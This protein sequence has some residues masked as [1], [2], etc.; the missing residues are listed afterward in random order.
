MSDLALFDVDTDPVPERESA[1]QKRTRRQAEI[2]AHGFH[3]L[4]LAL[5]RTVLRLHPEAAPPA[6]RGAPG[7]RCG[8]CRFLAGW[9]AHGYLKCLRGQ[10]G[11]ADPPLASHGAGTDIRQWWPACDFQAIQTEGADSGALHDQ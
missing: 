8:R 11:K 7:L 2:L 5:P 6:D 4:G 3:P 1:D 10:A 9:G